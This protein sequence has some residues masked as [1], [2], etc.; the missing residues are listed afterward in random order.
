MVYQENTY[1]DL[2]PTSPNIYYK[3]YSIDAVIGWSLEYAIR[4][5]FDVFAAAR[6]DYGINNVEQ[7]G[8]TYNGIKIFDGGGSHQMTYGLHFGVNYVFHRPD[9]LLLPT[10]TWRF[11]TY[12]KQQKKG[13]RK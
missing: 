5:N 2:P 1:F 11:R 4:K 7:K 9:H 12:R 13:R 8:A 10:N 6:V 3:K